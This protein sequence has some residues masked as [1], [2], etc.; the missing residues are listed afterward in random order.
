MK[1]SIKMIALCSTSLFFACGDDSHATT[2]PA[3]VVLTGNALNENF[4]TFGQSCVAD[5][6]NYNPDIAK[7]D[8]TLWPTCIVDADKTDK[9]VLVDPMGQTPAASSRTEAFEGFRAKLDYTSMVASEQDFADIRTAYLIPE[10]LQSRI[11]RRPDYHW[12]EFP[13]P[14]LNACKHTPVD[15][16]YEKVCA[17]PLQIEPIIN[18]AFSI[19]QAQAGHSPAE[20]RIQMARLEAAFLW[21]FYL[22]V[23]SEI[24]TARTEDPAD[25]DSSLGYYTANHEENAATIS[26]LA[27]YVRDLDPATHARVWNGHRAARCWRSQAGDT[28]SLLFDKIGDAPDDLRWKAARKQLDQAA[29][30]GISLIVKDRLGE[31]NTE[32][33][34]EVKAA[35]WA[36]IK[37][38]GPVLYRA[39]DILAPSQSTALKAEIDKTDT[40]MVNAQAAIDAI[41]NVYV[42]P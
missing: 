16:A 31:F 12:V 22:S 6:T 24:H 20:V 18:E 7:R 27:R 38:L 23:Y 32:A 3:P 17:G 1:V 37:V 42:C 13:I 30:H 35:H 11:T 25:V 26:G 15:P 4:G 39:M 21:F 28:G 29:L 2:I 9:W 5:S 40:S 33:D 10:G 8:Q 41:S 36:F 14:D 34:A 19:G